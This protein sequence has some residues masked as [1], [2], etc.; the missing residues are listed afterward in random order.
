RPGRETKPPQIEA[1]LS[2]YRQR[3]FILIGDSGEDD[4]EIYSAAFR[5]RPNQIE[6]IYIRN[7]TAAR[8]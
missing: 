6:R 7:V 3:R 2:R 4:P 5:A 1:I 8:R